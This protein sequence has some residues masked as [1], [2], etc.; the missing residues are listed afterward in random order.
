MSLLEV[1]RAR[2]ALPLL[3]LGVGGEPDLGST[4]GSCRL[5]ELPYSGHEPGDG[6]VVTAHL[7]FELV[8]LV[9]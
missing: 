4:D 7:P 8:E 5:H 2:L 3:R 1:F 9:D 6:V